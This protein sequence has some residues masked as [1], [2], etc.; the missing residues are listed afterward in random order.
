[1][2]DNELP[3]YIQRFLSG[4]CS[5]EDIRQ[6]IED[7]QENRN[8]D[9]YNGHLDKIWLDSLNL[10]STDEEEKS[11]LEESTKLLTKL[12]RKESLAKRFKLVAGI[13]A[14]IAVLLGVVYGSIKYDSFGQ[15]QRVEYAEI[16]TNFGQTRSI[17]LPD[18]TQVTLNSCSKLVY[19]EQ[20]LDD[21]RKVELVGQAFFKVANNEKQPFVVH[22]NKFDVKVLGTQFDIRAY[23]EDEILSVDVESGKVQVDMP[24]AMIRLVAHEKLIINTHNNNHYKET[25]SGKVAVWRSGK[26]LFRKTP[27]KEVAKELERVYNCQITFKEGQSFDNLI[28]GEH[29]NQSLESVLESLEQVSSIYHTRDSITK[30]ILLYKK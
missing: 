15:I 26:L 22:T 9:I 16:Q 13:A 10:K 7:V 21:C 20:F 12:T 6:V 18:G 4:K 28:S 8:M 25:V 2:S 24:E 5:E 11:Y 30:E 14:S 29:S 3:G 23:T 1:M 19:P 17:T 27:I